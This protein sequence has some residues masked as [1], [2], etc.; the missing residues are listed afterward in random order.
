[1]PDIFFFYLHFEFSYQIRV[2]KYSILNFEA[3]VAW[4]GVNCF[5]V[6]FT[7][8]VLQNLA[9]WV[10]NGT[11]VHI[12][13]PQTVYIFTFFFFFQTKFLGK[14]RFKCC[15]Y[16]IVDPNDLNSCCL[17]WLMIFLVSSMENGFGSVYV[18]YLSWKELILHG[19]D[20]D[21]IS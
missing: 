13:G 10:R 7:L 2:N 21:Q 12:V 11:A 19:I 18:L 1:M 4:C 8:H 3:L 15:M 17:C 5:M 20:N 9:T 16:I 14:T 6:Y